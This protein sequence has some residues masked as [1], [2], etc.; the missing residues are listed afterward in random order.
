VSSKNIVEKVKKR[1]GNPIA[2]R[3]LAY[4]GHLIVVTI[5]GVV[6]IPYFRANPTSIH[7]YFKDVGSI[8]KFFGPLLPSIFFV[9]ILF[10]LFNPRIKTWQSWIK[11]PPVWLAWCV[12]FFLIAVADH[13]WGVGPNE[14]K[15]EWWHWLVYG[16]CPVLGF[17]LFRWL[18]SPL[19]T[20]PE[21]NSTNNTT[22]QNPSASASVP[23]SNPPTIDDLLRNQ[24]VFEAWLLSEKPAEVDLIGTQRIANRLAEYLKTRDGNI[25]LVGSYGS[26]K[27]TVIGMI[28]QQ[29]K[30]S[31]DSTLPKILFVE[32]SCWG[33]EDASGAVQQ[34]LSQA[35]DEV[36]KETDC[37]SLR[38]IP[39]NYRK[40]F[41]AGGDW[42]RTL[43]DLVIGSSD[44]IEQFRKLS[45]NLELINAK[46]VVVVEDLDRTKSSKFDR[47]EVLAVLQRLSKNTK[48]IS[49]ILAAGQ[50]Q[51]KDIDF[52]K[53]CERIEFVPELTTQNISGMIIATRSI[54]LGQYSKIRT[55]EQENPWGYQRHCFFREFGMP[56]D[57]DFAIG[58]LNTPRSLKIALRRTY[59]TWVNV[60]RD[61]IDFD[62]LFVVNSL[63]QMAPEVISFL[64]RNIDSLASLS[65][66][67]EQTDSSQN[68][69]LGVRIKQEWQTT[70]ECFDGNLLS[71]Q[72]AIKFLFPKVAELLFDL[73][74]RSRRGYQTVE[75]SRYW[76]RAINEEIEQNG[77]KDQE[78]L[79]D[80]E[81]WQNTKLSN[82]RMLVRLK[83]DY[84]YAAQWQYFAD[85]LLIDDNSI[86]QVADDYFEH[87]KS[88]EGVCIYSNDRNN[89]GG[90]SAGFWEV[91]E[92]LKR[93]TSRNRLHEWVSKQLNE[94]L[95]SSLSLMVDLLNIFCGERG[96]VDQQ[97]VGDIEKALAQLAQRQITTAKSL[98]D[99]CHPQAEL[100]LHYW[101]NPPESIRPFHP[102]DLDWSWLGSILL[103]CL[104]TSEY[105]DYFLKEV[106][107]LLTE[108]E[109]NGLGKRPH[110]T[111]CQHVLESVF[112][113]NKNDLFETLKSLKST[114]PE[115]FKSRIDIITTSAP[116]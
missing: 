63:R 32:Q 90:W 50:T 42:L 41:S 39:E 10:K 62:Q 96:C 45:E 38:S 100:I 109:G 104:Q 57:L 94:S 7:E 47:Q 1:F 12:A 116:K 14:F 15:P 44:P 73:N 65:G 103:E 85:R 61:E 99:T 68:E 70:S 108:S 72:A 86:F 31:S 17:G 75:T 83:S 102:K 82:C 67:P 20:K 51:S 56:T 29:L 91:C 5:A 101:I 76:L 89:S 55:R 92:L 19:R 37:F 113:S 16:I 107:Y 105:R 110:H 34:I 98:W 49:F 115:S 36:S 53:L 18:K 88:K 71:I 23:E 77:I 84:Q 6:L 114:C 30:K 52:A 11:N 21:T 54:C 48:R 8:P 59:Q 46:L 43:A 80:I 9:W 3:W 2:Q 25:G 40:T 112:A 24:S 66:H 69:R 93:G 33:F 35:V 60:L 87:F 26:G 64:S 4:V 58:L 27:S 81:D 74:S 97:Q 111:I 79:A 95:T 13:A 22:L 106:V 28:Q 78:I